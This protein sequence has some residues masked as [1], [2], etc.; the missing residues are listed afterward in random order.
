[1]E[2]TVAITI[3]V[4]TNEI[5]SILVL[6]MKEIVFLV[7]AWVQI[8]QTQDKLACLCGHDGKIRN[9]VAITQDKNCMGA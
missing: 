9:T 5:L 6:G 4:V 7:A 1:M 2:L 3:A 8:D